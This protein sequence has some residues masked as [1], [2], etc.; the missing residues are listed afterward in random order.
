MGPAPE[1]AC[2][3]WVLAAA[4]AAGTGKYLRG[5]KPVEPSAEARD[6]EAAAR[7]WKLSAELAGTRDTGF[8]HQ[9]R[10]P[11]PLLPIPKAAAARIIGR[12]VR[13]ALCGS[14]LER[15]TGL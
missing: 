8:E 6:E 3:A 5:G 7:L 13:I 11:T 12:R 14:K 9:G 15:E 10:P 2:E 1:A 4:A